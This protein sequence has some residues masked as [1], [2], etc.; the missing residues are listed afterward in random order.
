[1]FA[2]LYGKT[3]RHRNASR[4]GS[5]YAQIP[6]NRKYARHTGPHGEAPELVRKQKESEGKEEVKAFIVVLPGKNG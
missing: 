3:H 6:R 2:S 1:L 5:L 4:D